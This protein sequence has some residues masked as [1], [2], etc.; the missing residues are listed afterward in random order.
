MERARFEALLALARD[1]LGDE[2]LAVRRAD[3]AALA[4]EE[5]VAYALSPAGYSS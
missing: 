1:R 4:L 5:A 3:G 2:E